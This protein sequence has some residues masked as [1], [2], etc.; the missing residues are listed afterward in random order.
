MDGWTLKSYLRAVAVFL[1]VL[2]LAIILSS[3][4]Q[5]VE[6]T[7]HRSNG[8]TVYR[9][10]TIEGCGVYEIHRGAIST[11]VYTTICSSG[12]SSTQWSHSCGK[13]CTRTEQ[14]ATVRKEH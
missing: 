2:L 10:T 14:V 5:E 6:S 11:T 4:T 3:C 8:V 13:N 9:I 12:Q 7:E 1:V